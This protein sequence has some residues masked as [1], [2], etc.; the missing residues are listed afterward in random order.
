MNVGTRLG[1]ISKTVLDTVLISVFVL[2]YLSPRSERLAVFGYSNGSSFTDNSK[3]Q[4][5]YSNR[6]EPDLRSVWLTRDESIVEELRSKG[7]EVHRFRSWRGIYLTL[8]AGVVFI[9]HSRRDVP[10]WATGGADVVR[11]GHGIPF[12]KFGRADPGYRD[13]KGDVKRIGYELLVGNYTHSIATSDEFAPYVAEATGLD[14]TEVHVTGLPRMDMP[15]VPDEDRDLYCDDDLLRT[16][17]TDLSESTIVFYFPTWRDGD[18][19]PVPEELDLEALDATLRETDSYLLTRPHPN[20]SGWDLDAA[21]LER[22]VTLDMDSDFY[23]V[24]EHVDLFVTDYSS[25][26]HDSVYYGVPVVFF[27]HD[28]STY[29][30]KREFFFEYESVPGDVVTSSDAFLDRIGDIL[31]DPDVYERRYEDELEA[32]RN[33]TFEYLD[34]HNCERVS[35]TFVDG[36]RGSRGRS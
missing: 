27:A 25:L 22:V 10:W 32:W 31:E 18:F 1:V 14:E 36:G 30:D 13:R 35:R 17:R 9:T 33:E 2:S 5:L 20:T 15:D 26:F 3:Y 12:K 34:G 11:L 23:P 24:F 16:L 29:T 6:D 28:L 21:E 7:Y 8:R 19:G 4:F